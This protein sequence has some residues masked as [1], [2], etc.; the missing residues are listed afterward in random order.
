MINQPITIEKRMIRL[1][2]WIVDDHWSSQLT[3]SLSSDALDLFILNIERI[4]RYFMYPSRIGWQSWQL[5]SNNWKSIDWITKRNQKSK[6]LDW[7]SSISILVKGLLGP[8]ILFVAT[9][10]VYVYLTCAP[11][12][13][14]NM[15]KNGGKS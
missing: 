11:S 9:F 10:K 6:I 4:G 7:K 13:V 3:R 2:T 14:V 15:A 8:N 1:N 5:N 12:F